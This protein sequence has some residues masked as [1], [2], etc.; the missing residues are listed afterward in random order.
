[1]SNMSPTEKFDQGVRRVR[2]CLAGNYSKTQFSMLKELMGPAA[3][4]IIDGQ[5]SRSCWEQIDRVKIMCLAFMVKDANVMLLGPYGAGKTYSVGLA[6]EVF[7]QE[8]FRVQGSVNTDPA[9]FS[10]QVDV[11][12]L[13]E[14]NK[15]ALVI[16]DYAKSE[17][18]P[19]VLFVDEINRMA[20]HEMNYLTAILAERKLDSE[21]KHTLETKDK[22]IGVEGLTVFA[23]RNRQD[24]ATFEMPYHNVDR[25]SMSLLFELDN[26]G[27]LEAKNNYNALKSR[28]DTLQLFDQEELGAIREEI[29]KM[30]VK[31]QTVAFLDS[32]VKQFSHC[33]E[34][35][36]QREFVQQDPCGQCNKNGQVCSCL[37]QDFYLSGR[38]KEQILAFGRAEAYVQGAKAVEPEHLKPFLFPALVHKL[39]LKPTVAQVVLAQEHLRVHLPST[40]AAAGMVPYYDAAFAL[41]SSASAEAMKLSNE[42]TDKNGPIKQELAKLD[43]ALMEHVFG[44]LTDTCDGKRFVLFENDQLQGPGFNKSIESRYLLSQI[45]QR[46]G[47]AE[48]ILMEFGNHQTSDELLKNIS[49]SGAGFYKTM[50]KALGDPYIATRV[51]S[52]ASGQGDPNVVTPA[53]P[54]AKSKKAIG[55]GKLKA[56]FEHFG[57]NPKD[58]QIMLVID[59]YKKVAAVDDSFFKGH[60]DEVLANEKANQ[61][62]VATATV[63]YALCTAAMDLGREDDALYA[64]KALN[65]F[66]KRSVDAMSGADAG[67][68]LDEAVGFGR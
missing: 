55:P 54:K 68:T 39:R 17:G 34:F 35:G 41:V 9:N 11:K 6:S 52:I 46:I 61:N 59:G 5:V 26:L 30:P 15:F 14:K 33:G 40:S 10:G 48:E 38:T 53:E 18:K 51:A 19:A 44:K 62:Q 42:L 67:P 7:G 4:E 63:L 32:F 43:S 49:A 45:S 31:V 16:P 12:S 37:E 56:V 20:P 65:A 1:M 58:M 50:V 21:A 60:V 28:M 27:T 66:H 24:S 2:Q 36:S 8:V 13:V 3:D 25:F 57:I 23:T 64:Y 47:A 29:G 22:M